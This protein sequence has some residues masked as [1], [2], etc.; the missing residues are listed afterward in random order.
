[1]NL[2]DIALIA[3][4]LFSII[5]GVWKG[6]VREIFNI[7]GVLAAILLALTLATSLAPHMKRILPYD[8]SGYAESLIL[9][10]VA[11]LIA[12]GLLGVLLTK[13][14]EAAQLGGMN[15]ALG[16]VFGLLR[17]MLIALFLVLGLTLFLP[18]GSRVLSGSK[19]TP[20]LGMGARALAPLLPEQAEVTLR[21]RLD[22][23]P[24]P[25]ASAPPAGSV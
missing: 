18:S 14:L 11:T 2:L 17:G 1:M 7:V 23:L 4:T 24:R 19:L 8:T 3:I 12:A 16:G 25:G 9:I 21:R 20:Y 6:L 15:R 5:A 13:V 22:A 10:F